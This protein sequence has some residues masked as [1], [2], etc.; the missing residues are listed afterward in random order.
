MTLAARLS[1]LATRVAVEIKAA[2]VRIAA[3]EENAP[4]V[5]KTETEWATIDP[6]TPGVVY[7][8]VAD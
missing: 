6:G 4:V 7:V 2:L 5:V 3:L 8:I 1:A